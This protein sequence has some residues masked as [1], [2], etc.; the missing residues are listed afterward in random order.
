MRAWSV[1]A[2]DRD[3]VPLDR[4]TPQPAGTE[5]LLEVRAAGVCHS[6]LHICE[7]HYDLGGGHRA[8]M[9]DRGIRL[10]FA[11]GHEVVGTIVAAGPDAGD[12]AVGAIR[13]VYPWIG[14][15]RCAV[16]ARGE[17][18][19][20]AAPRFVGIFRDGGYATHVLVPHPRYLLDVAG[21][22]AEA[23][24]PLACSGLTT[25]AALQ[26]IDPAIL[27]HEPVL[28]IG[29]GGLGL[30]A[31]SILARLGGHGAIVAD[32]DPAKRAA[33]LSMGALA[34]VGT[35]APLT[36]P[37]RA[38]IDFVG[39]PST[40]QW[41]LENLHKGGKLIVVGLIGGAITLPIPPLATRATTIQGSYVGTLAE[42][43]ALMAL[44]RA[45]PLAPIPTS[46]RPLDEANA[47]LADLR[48]GRVTGRAV[49]MPRH[50]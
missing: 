50:A 35:D 12:V 9:A 5:V 17:E 7:G 48:A 8:Y 4:P 6:D 19:Y 23:A 3:L 43:E 28:L 14:C 27:F 34:V 36:A 15:G 44:V 26:K 46:V 37:V 16:C 10:P 20:C 32:I 21:L 13:L 40:V 1:T 11:P 25:F 2:W 47:A 30:M 42:L 18:P 33:A 45:R 41:A 29:A 22:A 24:A 31:V 39:A 49:L 38:A